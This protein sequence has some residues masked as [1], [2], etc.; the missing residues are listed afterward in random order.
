MSRIRT[1]KPEFWTSEQ[2]I[3][4]SS[5]ARLLFVGLWNFCDDNGV[6][7]ASYIRI[8]AEVFPAD[9]LDVNEIK[10]CVNEL[11]RSDGTGVI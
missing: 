11:C 2:V 10:N 1:I 8:K 9:N 6:H 4:C 3:A 7:P 5:N